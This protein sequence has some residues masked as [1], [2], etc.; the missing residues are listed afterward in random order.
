M[1]ARNHW[2]TFPDDFI[3]RW[4]AFLPAPRGSCEAA[5][6][7]GTALVEAGARHEVYRL[8][9]MPAGEPYEVSEGSFDAYLRRQLER[10]G[11][12]PLFP[13]DERPGN[14]SWATARLACYRPAGLV[15][16]VVGDVGALLREL[17]PECLETRGRFMR[18]A[19]PVAIVGMA[20]PADRTEEIRIQIRLDTD[21]WFSRVLGM[22][23]EPDGDKPDWYD[24]HPLA[25]RHTPRL[26]AFLRELRALTLSLGGRW[27]ALEVDA[28]AA[29]YESQWDEHGIKLQPDPSA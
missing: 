29:N 14:D 2:M 25:Q 11:L 17:R 16:E 6:R 12:V 20:F 28:V 22:L 9:R 26:N 15:E 1:P 18:A 3:V 21:L 19:P 13:R 4:G 5:I 8:V 10:R 23:E 7:F 24:N 27:E